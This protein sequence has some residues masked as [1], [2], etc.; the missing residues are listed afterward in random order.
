MQEQLSTEMGT[1]AEAYAAEFEFTCWYIS[2]YIQRQF[3]EWVNSVALPISIYLGNT[4][5]L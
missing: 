3:T 4:T 1:W 2:K 5:Q